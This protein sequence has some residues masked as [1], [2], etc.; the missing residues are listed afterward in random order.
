MSS[1]RG[2]NG[3]WGVKKGSLEEEEEE[4]E[5]GG[6]GEAKTEKGEE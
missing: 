1:S 6:E 3:A 2:R 5:E 4:E